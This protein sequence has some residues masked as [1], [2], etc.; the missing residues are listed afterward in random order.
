MLV[1]VAVVTI[2]DGTDLERTIEAT[3]VPD[4]R[5]DACLSEMDT[6]YRIPI[7]LAGEACGPIQAACNIPFERYRRYLS[8]RAGSET[9]K[10]FESTASQLRSRGIGDVFAVDRSSREGFRPR[11]PNDPERSASL[12]V[13]LTVDRAHEAASRVSGCSVRRILVAGWWPRGMK[14]RARSH[15]KL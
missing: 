5:S 14:H 12:R 4:E 10:K 6:L 8:D 15:G 3:A 11:L 1:S 9:G 13:R 2:A 7:R